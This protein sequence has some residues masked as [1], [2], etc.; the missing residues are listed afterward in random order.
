MILS[1]AQWVQSTALFTAIR[2]SWYV[3][4]AIMSTHLCAI[5]L[6]GGMILMTDLRL[7]GVTLRQRTVTEVVRQLRPLKYAG[8]ILLATCGILMAGSKAEEYYYNI[9]FRTKMLLLCLVLVHALVFRRSVYHNTEAFDRA[10]RVP[11]RAKLA[12]SLS[13]VLWTCLV[14][15]GRGIGY[16]EPPLDKLHAQLMPAQSAALSR[17]AAGCDISALPCDQS[18][19]AGSGSLLK[20]KP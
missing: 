13:L 9:F 4:P 8:F 1:F 19:W 17:A 15:A 12:A 18:H 11:G 14:I 16:I 10:G 7:L 20:I 6:F 5:A 3:Y 2:G